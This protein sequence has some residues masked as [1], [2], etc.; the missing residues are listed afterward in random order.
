MTGQL[1]KVYEL[2][3]YSLKEGVQIPVNQLQAG[4]YYLEIDAGKKT[5]VRF[6]KL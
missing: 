1:I 5:G 2:D 6:I 4:M 3:A